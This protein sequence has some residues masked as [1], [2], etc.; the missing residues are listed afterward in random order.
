MGSEV[1]QM[2]TQNTQT[3]LSNLSSNDILSMM[4]SN[5]KSTI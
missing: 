4:Q 5:N 2:L 1:L 3:A